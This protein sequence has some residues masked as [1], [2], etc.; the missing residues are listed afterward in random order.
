[1]P[2]LSDTAIAQTWAGLRPCTPDELPILGHDPQI[3]GLIYATGHYRNGIL[4]A[5]ITA[6]SISDL[7]VKGESSTDLT[8]FSIARFEA[9]SVAG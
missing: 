7:V 4:L 6:Q 8:P 1:M 5:P 3:D 2:G 9:R